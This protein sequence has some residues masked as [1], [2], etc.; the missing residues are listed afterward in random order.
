VP[1]RGIQVPGGPVYDVLLSPV[2]G[3][4]SAQAVIA[5]IILEGEGTPG[6]SPTSHFARFCQVLQE[7]MAAKLEDP[8]FEPARP[9]I[10]NP[11]QAR[12]EVPATLALVELFDQAY[13]TLMLLLIRYFAHSDE[14]AAELAALQ[15]VAFFPMM[16]AVIRPLGE[17]L[18][19]LPVHSDQI[20]TAGAGF[21]LTRNVSLLPH[22]RSAWIVIGDQLAVLA[23]QAQQC[24]LDSSYPPAVQQRLTLIAQNL[25]RMA[26]DFAAALETPR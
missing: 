14:T 10:S 13:R 8:D 21:R 16:T 26:G 15:H 17:L 11:D 19:L 3:N 6:N 4:A 1:I 22:R 20:E 23:R 18:T 2:T 7:L 25:V 12:I 24:A 9:V 5:R